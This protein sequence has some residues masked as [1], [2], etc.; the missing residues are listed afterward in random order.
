[1]F[2]NG[3]ST[4]KIVNMIIKTPL[5]IFSYAGNFSVCLFYLISGF[6]I[7]YAYFYKNNRTQKIDSIFK[8]YFQLV[9]PI[10]LSNIIIFAIL[11]SGLFR[12]DN[13]INLYSQNGF[14]NY[15]KNF[16]MNFFDVIS[17]SFYNIFS[18]GNAAINPPLWTM[19]NEL[20]FSVIVMLILSIFGNNKNRIYV[21]LF[22]I[23]FFPDSYL[24]CFIFGVV[25]LELSINKNDFLLKIN[26]IDV[27]IIIFLLG[28]Y[29]SSY[30]YLASQS[31]IYSLLDFDLVNLDKNVI[32]HGLGA[33]LIMLFILLSKKMQKILSNKFFV[34]LGNISLNIYLFHW[35]I[36]NTISMY[37][38]Y[39]LLLLFEYFI[40]VLI[41][42]IISTIITIV[43]S[44]YFDK[45][46]KS[47]TKFFCDK[48][49]RKLKIN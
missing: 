27:K 15:Y 24:M 18:T 43:V 2:C 12:T 47:I 31:K 26:R 33:M 44:K 25:L 16:D 36:I 46:I 13:L 30:T 45:Y 8:R 37:I 17:T 23:L 6:L 34:K 1:M 20:I 11:K 38:V 9:I 35:V 14:D 28:L 49:T 29:L 3:N 4:N 41:S 39:K 5:N 48:I 32:Y 10:L 21:Y 19:K 7:S 22:I 42:F 40:S